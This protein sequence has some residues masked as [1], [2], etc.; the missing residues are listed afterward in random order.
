MTFR[1]GTAWGG[2]RGSA[3]GLG[4]L[5]SV[6]ALTFSPPFW[7]SIQHGKSSHVATGLFHAS[8]VAVIHRDVVVGRGAVAELLGHLLRWALAL[9]LGWRVSAHGHEPL[10]ARTFGW[11]TIIWVEVQRLVQIV[12]ASNSLERPLPVVLWRCPSEPKS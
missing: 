2:G 9:G 4:S 6:R 7:R 11:H 8:V 12:Q 10:L 5:P 1:A 3:P